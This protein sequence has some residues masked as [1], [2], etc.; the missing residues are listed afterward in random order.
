MSIKENGKNL[1]IIPECIFKTNGIEY[2]IEHNLIVLF[3][4]KNYKEH[5]NFIYI[6]NC[7]Y[8]KINK[9]LYNFDVVNPLI[10]ID[11]TNYSL[12]LLVN[13][14]NIFYNDNNE[15]ISFE[16]LEDKTFSIYPGINIKNISF[17]KNKVYIN[18]Y[19]K[20]GILSNIKNKRLLNFEK[21]KILINKNSKQNCL[22]SQKYNILDDSE[23]DEL[24]E[25]DFEVEDIL[26]HKIEN[27]ENLFLV[28]WK[29]YEDIHNSWIKE[30]DFNDKDLLEEYI[31]KNNL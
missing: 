21:Y 13:K 12:N 31:L 27:S 2:D 22:I 30:Y 28:K 7:I 3:I 10:K 24:E 20:E 29:G 15:F 5:S 14:E 26:G 11:N 4:D 6:I 16:S 9:Y 1:N 17:I 25:E 18:I 8:D 19:L 23:Y